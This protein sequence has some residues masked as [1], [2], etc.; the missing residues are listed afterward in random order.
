MVASLLEMRKR[1]FFPSLRT[2]KRLFHPKRKFFVVVVDPV[3]QS[4]IWAICSGE[5]QIRRSFK[6]DA[7]IGLLILFSST[8][9][10]VK[11]IARVSNFYLLFYIRDYKSTPR[12]IFD[13]K[14]ADLIVALK[15]I[16]MPKFTFGGYKNGKIIYPESLD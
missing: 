10:L 1:E 15:S 8:S 12:I 13:L 2:L 9:F 11:K 16:K 6:Y 7:A 4:G 3:A 14:I 5:V